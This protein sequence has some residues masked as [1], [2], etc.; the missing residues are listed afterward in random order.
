[1]TQSNELARPV[2]GRG[3]GFDTDAARLQVSKQRQKLIAAN[4]TPKY[5]HA[6]AINAMNL[7]NILRDIET[8]RGY[9]HGT[10]PSCWLAYDSASMAHRDAAG[11]GPSTPSRCWLERE[12]SMDSGGPG[13]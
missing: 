7:K 1:M 4:F 12:A 5:R 2:M 8:D 3:T 13:S 11:S 9:L 6:F 10:T